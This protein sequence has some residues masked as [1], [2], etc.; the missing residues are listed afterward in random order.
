MGGGPSQEQ[1]NA[2]QAQANLSNQT[3]QTAADQT[4][5]MESQEQKID[6]FA[7]S[8]LN[9]GLP[10][11]NSLTDYSNGTTAAAY[12]PGR[13]AILRKYDTMSG[14][15]SGMKDQTLADYDA[16]E[17]RAFDQ[18]QVNNMLLN[19]QSKQGAAALLTGQEQISNPVGYT[20]AAMQGNQSIMQAP[21]QTPGIAGLL[22][23][24]AQGV[25]SKLPT[26]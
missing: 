10:F 3:A 12:A 26:F 6:P 5:F 20:S 4:K 21:L 13:A 23:G 24:L 14:L 18:N 8:R 11:Y 9:S 22:G 25:I 7:T 19:E 2:A 16:N 1:K 15:P 17:A